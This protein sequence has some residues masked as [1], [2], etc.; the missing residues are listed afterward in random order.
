MHCSDDNVCVIQ[1]GR[2]LEVLCTGGVTMMCGVFLDK[3]DEILQ[4]TG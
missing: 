4:C 3:T 2:Q 1:I